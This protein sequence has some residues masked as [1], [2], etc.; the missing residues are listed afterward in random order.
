MP[1]VCY[2]CFQEE[3]SA[4]HLFMECQIIKKIRRYIHGKVQMSQQ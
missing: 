3:E 1:N 4:S 2:M